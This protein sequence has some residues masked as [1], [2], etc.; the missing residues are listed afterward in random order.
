MTKE[1]IINKRKNDEKNDYPFVNQDIYI[2]FQKSEQ[3]FHFH[4]KQNIKPSFLIPF[5]MEHNF[6][7]FSFPIS[8]KRNEEGQ[9]EECNNC[10]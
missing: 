3:A 2:H 4:V 6:I 9:L 8:L 7:S 5:P 1:M 10:I